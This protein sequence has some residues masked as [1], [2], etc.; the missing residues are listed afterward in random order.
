[1]R[2]LLIR[3]DSSFLISHPPTGLGCIAH[4]LREARND[5]ILILDLHL[6]KLSPQGLAARVRDFDPQVVG[7]SSMDYNRAQL[8]ALTSLLKREA[9]EAPVVLGG[10]ITSGLPH[11]AF[12]DPNLDVAVVGEGEVTAVELMNALDGGGDLSAVPGLVFR[13]KGGLVHTP[14]REP[15][16]DLD[17]VK[18]AWDLVDPLPYFRQF[19]RSGTIRVRRHYRTW[20][21]HTSRGCPRR[22]IYCHNIF[23][24]SFRAQSPD[25]VME[26]VHL[27]RDRYG[28][29]Q[30]ELMEDNFIKDRGR[31][32][33]I[34]ARIRDEAPGMAL[35]F[36]PG[37]RVDGL[38]EELL[39]RMAEAGGFY[40]SFPVETASPRIQKLAR[41]NLDLSLVYPM[42][43]AAMRRGFHTNGFFMLGFPGETLDEM[44]KTVLFACKSPLHTAM[45]YY[46]VPYPGTE[47]H[48][49]A[50][51]SDDKAPL[52][53]FHEF[54]ANVSAVSDEELRRMVRSAYRKFYLNPLRL[55]RGAWKIPKTGNFF[56]TMLT[57][58]R[59]LVSDTAI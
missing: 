6:L 20:P 54:P 38:D 13:S 51:L 52:G 50:G 7:I 1:M 11:L 2:V 43:R 33:E 47:L 39:D 26:E 14:P 23:G 18:V 35:S 44:K 4:A 45:F 32:M 58:G 16:E 9:P 41:K 3:P 31:A 24:K 28:V 21:L 57:L 15:M 55:I 56:P 36:S 40:L 5:E 12:A 37:L 48:R 34:L 25:S 8:P 10:P 59:L 46:V 29:R 22:C 17:R 27:L 19:R 42:I 49:M 53:G 30:L